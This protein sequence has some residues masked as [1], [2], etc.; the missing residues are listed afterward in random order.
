MC[1]VVWVWAAVL[2]MC[3]DH[4]LPVTILFSFSLLIN[5]QTMLFADS[6]YRASVENLEQARQQW[7]REMTNLCN[8]SMNWTENVIYSAC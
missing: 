6:S 7:E 2:C 8:V 1:L 3:L 5:D 4:L